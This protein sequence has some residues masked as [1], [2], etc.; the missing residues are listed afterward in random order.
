MTHRNWPQK[1][2]SFR[3]SARRFDVE[4]LMTTIRF[5]S[6]R[7][8]EAA[9]AC[10]AVSLTV[11]SDGPTSPRLG[12]IVV[13]IQTSGGD[14]DI[15][16]YDFLVDSG[17]R[18]RL[19]VGVGVIGL[20]ETWRVETTVTGVSPGTH[21]VTLQAVADNCTVNDT[22]SRS[23]TLTAGQAVKVAYSVVCFATGVEV[24]TH[25]TGPDVPFVYDLVVDQSSI[26]ITPNRTQIV[27]RLAPGAHVV[28]LRMRT[29]NCSVVGGDQTIAVPARTVTP[30]RF[31]II[32]V[33]VVRL[34]KI[35]YVADTIV[36]GKAERWIAL[37]KP[38]GSG[39]RKLVVGE[40]PA[41][42]PNGTGLAFST[43]SCNGFDDYYG[44]ACV[45]G[46][47]M[48]DPETLNMHDLGAGATSGVKPA[49]SPTGDV[50]A[51]TRC[52]EY[53]DVKRLY[54]T[55]VDGSS[56]EHLDIADVFNVR[57]PAWS[58]DGQRI[59]FSCSIRSSSELCV[60]NKDGSGLVQLTNDAA[61]EGDPAWSPDGSRIAFSR[62][63]PGSPPEIVLIAPGG[64]DVTRVTEGFEPAW[65]RDGSKLV[66]TGLNG[67]YTINPDGS[68]LTRLTT[69]AHHA[70]AWR[71]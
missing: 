11:C 34:E 70:P 53:A 20:D 26:P 33:P 42:S 31:E 9:V 37:I 7:R 29:E 55:R 6:R 3:L 1:V 50:I 13:S 10:L 71:P 18:H 22:D 16:G 39:A 4:A 15:D 36:N 69:G 23:I 57:D 54:L 62:Y 64:G 52:C 35:A 5:I 17:P 47:V 51:F 28:A 63:L 68:H 24:T 67:L 41:W 25:T 66:F 27:S 12:T 32:C 56:T 38:D 30:V 21:V 65:S 45:G 44:Y 19:G 59:A 43:A 49:W 58:P 46:I 2:T 14:P 8:L 60:I 40:S 61:S 48:I